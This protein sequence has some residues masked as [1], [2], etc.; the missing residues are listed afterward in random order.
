MSAAR[1]RGGTHLI[2]GRWAWPRCGHPQG[3]FAHSAHPVVVKNCP[4]SSLTVF[5]PVPLSTM[6]ARLAVSGL[7]ER[8]HEQP[9]PAD[10]RYEP[11]TTSVPAWKVPSRKLVAA[12]RAWSGQKLLSAAETTA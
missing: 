8:C 11:G 1:L 9:F 3:T 10:V 6:P 5:A 4:S 12:G 7:V 2:I